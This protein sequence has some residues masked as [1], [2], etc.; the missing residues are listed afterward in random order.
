[1][2]LMACVRPL[3]IEA[4]D[5][6]QVGIDDDRHGVI[7]DHA[8]GLVALQRPDRQQ[9]IDALVVM[10]QHRVDHVGVA[11]GLNQGEQRMLG[12]IGVPERKDRVVGEA[13]G[14]MD[15]L[16]EA[17]IL[18]GHVLVEVRRRKGMVHGRVEGLL[19]LLRAFDLDLAEFAFHLARVCW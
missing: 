4:L 8:P 3:G 18:P 16:V 6:L 11:L 2:V 14:A 1:M 17:A 13:L 7:A 19:V 15:V 12:A 5:A 9:M 10:G